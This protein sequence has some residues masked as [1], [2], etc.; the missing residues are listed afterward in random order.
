MLQIEAN[1]LKQSIGE[2]LQPIL[3]MASIMRADSAVKLAYTLPL[4]LLITVI[5]CQGLKKTD[6]IAVEENIE[7]KVAGN[8]CVLRLARM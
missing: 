3:P 6:F 1:R 2:D 8:L 4:Q 5:L 7:I